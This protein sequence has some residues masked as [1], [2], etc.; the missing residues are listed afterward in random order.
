M[1][2][3]I[4]DQNCRTSVFKIIQKKVYSLLRDG[5]ISHVKDMKQNFKPES[6][7]LFQRVLLRVGISV[8]LLLAEFQ[9]KPLA[10]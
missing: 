8:L 9:A 5:L 1:L 6:L 2:P 10:T 7:K 3:V 4:G